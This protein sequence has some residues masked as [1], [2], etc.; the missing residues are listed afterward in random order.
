[1]RK[2][3]WKTGGFIGEEKPIYR[4]EII[5]KGWKPSETLARKTVEENRML[6]DW[7]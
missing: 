7:E 3:G 4:A 1:M 2:R 5:C 6:I